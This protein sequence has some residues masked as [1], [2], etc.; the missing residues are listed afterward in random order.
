MYHYIVIWFYRLHSTKLEPIMLELIANSLAKTCIKL[1]SIEFSH[2][3]IGNEGLTSFIKNIP[4]ES[5]PN[6]K[7]LILNNN[8]FSK[9][10]LLL[11]ASQTVYC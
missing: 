4:S 2:C 11:Y 5:F 7:C 1:R 9:H 8:Y 3:G 10:I 6:L